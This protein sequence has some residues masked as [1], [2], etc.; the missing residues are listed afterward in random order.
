MLL[1]AGVGATLLLSSMVECFIT[2]SVHPVMVCEGQASIFS[3]SGRGRASP[4]LEF[5]LEWTASLSTVVDWI[6][7]G[8]MGGFLSVTGSESVT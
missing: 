7:L 3:V 4:L 2:L 1:P 6:L 8:A 5:G